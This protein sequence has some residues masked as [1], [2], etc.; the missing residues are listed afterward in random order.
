MPNLIAKL[1]YKHMDV[2]D[3][4]KGT[5]TKFSNHK[6]IELKY[7]GIIIGRDPEK[8]NRDLLVKVKEIKTPFWVKKS[9]LKKI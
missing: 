2:G 6:R 3:T 7:E 1:E 9:N 5:L 4:V 8:R